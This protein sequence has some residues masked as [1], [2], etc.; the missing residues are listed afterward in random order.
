M[1]CLVA[2]W[3]MVFTI[4]FYFQ[5]NTSPI[6]NIDTPMK[7]SITTCTTDIIAICL[8]G[9][10]FSTSSNFT[11]YFLSCPAV[12]ALCV[13]A[14]KPNQAAPAPTNTDIKPDCSNDGSGKSMNQ[15]VAK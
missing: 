14:Y 5:L 7:T 11:Y 12:G 10:I 15:N 3:T 13:P 8:I 9:C 2:K 4:N 6:T 1:Y